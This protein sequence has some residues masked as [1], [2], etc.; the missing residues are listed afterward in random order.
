MTGPARQFEEPFLHGVFDGELEDSCL[1]DGL[2]IL[3]QMLV[4]YD[5]AG[6]GEM[7]GAKSI[8]ED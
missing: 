2:R 5:I 1:D 8:N 3:A 4:R 7:N 6:K